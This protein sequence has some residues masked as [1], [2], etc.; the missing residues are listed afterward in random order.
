[1]TTTLLT[2]RLALLVSDVRLGTAEKRM[3]LTV[4]HLVPLLTKQPVA[5]FDSHIHAK[6]CIHFT[7]DV[8]TTL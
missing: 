3:I 7:N 4:V 5:T 8:L 1:M 6:R 2:G